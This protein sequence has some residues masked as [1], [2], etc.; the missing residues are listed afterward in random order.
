[1][2]THPYTVILLIIGYLYIFILLYFLSQDKMLNVYNVKY[3]IM[4]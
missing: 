1:M 3:V 4:F 2:N